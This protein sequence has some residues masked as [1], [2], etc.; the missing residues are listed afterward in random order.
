M[1]SIHTTILTVIFADDNPSEYSVTISRTEEGCVIEYLNIDEELLKVNI[2]K[3]VT[4]SESKDIEAE[5]YHHKA[6][7]LTHIINMCYNISDELECI[8]CTGADQMLS[9]I[10]SRVIY[11]KEVPRRIT[12]I[13]S[14]NDIFTW[15][16]DI[17]EIVNYMYDST[18][19][20]IE[21]HEEILE[22]LL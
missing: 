18:V 20:S 9:V 7:W 15:T 2:S 19:E 1:E 22:S 8:L 14:G 12:L 13:N 5:K 11:N 10:C 17:K 3:E 6:I 16:N 21:K 4:I